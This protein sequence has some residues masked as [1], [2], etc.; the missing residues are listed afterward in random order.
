MLRTQF[1]A[2]VTAGCVLALLGP[3][4]GAADETGDEDP[5]RNPL[6]LVESIEKR[7]AA[8]PWPATV[9]LRALLDDLMTIAS[10]ARTDPDGSGV[11]PIHTFRLMVRFRALLEGQF[12]P[13]PAPD[14]MVFMNMAPPGWKYPSGITPDAIKEDEIREAYEAA[15]AENSRL[16]KFRNRQA[17]LRQLVQLTMLGLENPRWFGLDLARDRAAVEAVLAEEVDDPCLRARL[18]KHVF[19]EPDAEPS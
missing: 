5:E 12:E 8:P 1:A 3:A 15:L 4:A 7:L 11:E 13:D 2:I 19:P 17:E 6:A 14:R 16:A 18:R 10:A 9:R